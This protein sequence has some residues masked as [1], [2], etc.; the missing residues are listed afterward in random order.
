MP[1]PSPSILRSRP[2]PGRLSPV[3]V[4]KRAF[5]A[6]TMLLPL[7]GAGVTIAA[8]PAAA[9]TVEQSIVDF[10]ASQAGAPYCFGG[11][12][13]HGPS[14]AT[15]SPPNPGCGSGAKGYDCMSLA[16]YA[17]YQAT[18][19]VLPSNGTQPAG[20]GTFIPPGNLPYTG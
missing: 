19:I 20:V 10:A 9:T 4:A 12:G 2:A 17:V 18:G 11:G 6:V 13:I 5:L 8:R 14:A 16:Q 3:S 15:I 1:P 7:F